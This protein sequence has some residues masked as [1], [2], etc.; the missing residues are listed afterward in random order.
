M[1]SL[2]VVVAVQRYVP[3]TLPRQGKLGPS[4]CCKWSG[5]VPR[6]WEWSVGTLCGAAVAVR[7]ASGKD[8]RRAPALGWPPSTCGR[9]CSLKA[10]I[11]RR[12]RLAVVRLG[13]VR[14][15]RSEGRKPCTPTV[16]GSVGATISFTLCRRTLWPQRRTEHASPDPL[17]W[18][19]RAQTQNER[20][21]HSFYIVENP[22]VDAEAAGDHHRPLH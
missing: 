20:R 7:I 4:L 19:K 5:A 8:E 3:R 17:L 15:R 14:R 6:V 21:F 10:A 16:H 13:D 18:P 9:R 22:Q 1:H 12:N 11:R 2:R